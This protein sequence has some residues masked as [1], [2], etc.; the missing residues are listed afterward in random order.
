MKN[1]GRSSGRVYENLK[2]TLK[3]QIEM[4]ELAQGEAVMAERKLA[5][6]FSISRESVR[7]G[8]REL[9]DEGYLKVVPAKGV[10][11]DYR[12]TRQ[13]PGSRTSTLGYL[14]WG[15]PEGIFRA[16]FF[17]GLISGV[18]QETQGQG[19]HLMLAAQQNGDSGQPPPMVQQRKVDGVLLEGAPIEIYHQI[20]KYVPVVVISNYYRRQ[21]SDQERGGDMVGTDNLRTF[22]DMFGYL[23]D[24]GHRKIA[25]ATPPIDHS[26][27]YERFEGYQLALLKY[28]LP[29][30]SEYVA[31]TPGLPEPESIIPLL[32]LEDR[33][34]AIMAANDMT[35]IQSLEAAKKMG[36]KVPED[37]SV[38][39]YDDVELAPTADPPLTTARVSTIDIG[40][41]AVRRL[42]EK[43]ENPD[44]EEIVTMISGDIITRDSCAPPRQA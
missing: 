6:L 41:L 8:L 10:F 27:F 2:E 42:V 44:R 33:P 15:S 19:Y 30:R 40:R 12:G 21:N 43:V 28:G 24:M 34:T 17:E 5:D 3:R 35:A 13:R 14:F 23:Y 31:F 32:Q 22:V 39:G 26:A 38:T 36:M 16:P 20:E 18:E 7:R 29:Y 9:I 11:V 37:L 4:G 1:L 25:F